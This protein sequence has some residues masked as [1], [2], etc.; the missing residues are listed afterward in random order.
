MD[1]GI[2]KYDALHNY[3][4]HALPASPGD[5]RPLQAD[6][7]QLVLLRTFF[8]F[9]LAADTTLRTWKTVLWPL[10]WVYITM[11]M[12]GGFNFA[13]VTCNIVR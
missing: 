6:I 13:S 9:L 11:V 12:S 4:T 5:S 8:V 1:T 3:M 7:V 10:A 2:V